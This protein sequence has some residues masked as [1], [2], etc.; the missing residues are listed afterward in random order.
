MSLSN[1]FSLGADRLILGQGDE[2]VNIVSQNGKD[3]KINGIVP[4]AGGSGVPA[5]G[6]IDFIGN[7]NCNDQAGG[8]AKGI[9]TAEKKVVSGLGGIETTGNL[10]IKSNGNLTIQG[11]GNF[12]QQ[13]NGKIS[14]G[15]GGIE[16][17]GDIQTLGAHDIVI[18]KD[19]YF[20]GQDIYHRTFNPE[21]QKSYKDYKQLVGKNDDNVFTGSNQF[22]SSV[23]E[24]SEK[25]SI[26]TRD[27][28]GLFTQ[29]IALNKSGNIESKTI[30]NTTLIKAN[31]LVCENGDPQDQLVKAR[32]YHF[33]P[34]PTETTGWIFSQKQPDNPALTEDNYLMLQ[35]TQATG[36]F[37]LV[38]SSFD[39]Q[40]PTPFDIILDPQNGKVK[41]TI[42]F[43]APEVNFRKNAT[44]AW[45]IYQPPAGDANESKLRIQ[46]YQD[47][48]GGVQILDNS[49]NIWVDFT[50][51]FNTFNKPTFINDALTMVGNII[52]NNSYG[53]LFGSYSFKP[54]QYSLTKTLT[55][56]GN[57]DTTNFTNMVFNC[58]TDTFTNINTGG[59]V[60][61]YNAALEGFYKV[62]ITQTGLSSAGNFSNCDMMFEYVYRL[63]TQSQPDIIITEPIYN[64]RIKPTNQARPTIQIDHLNT[65]VQSQPVFLLFSGQNS[66]ETMPIDVRL[67]KLNF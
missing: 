41:T 48:A 37:N 19:I 43:D 9:I 22:N 24:F 33:R 4:N 13:G 25:V 3:I 12:D 15:S 51:L 65:P 26:G 32:Q 62:T 52:I 7:L 17:R 6:D 42:S 39:P 8:G 28:E 21:E 36:S 45:S 60:P 30:N 20:D 29:N 47:N 35:N 67:T 40:N 58:R 54:I 44:D 49:N 5:V 56:A 27:G 61:F 59:S 63:S 64:Y 18:G 31:S 23:T 16:S 53:L 50:N 2:D 57:A 55:I 11:N 66:G 34:N 1:T 38:K 14:S 10:D 46:N